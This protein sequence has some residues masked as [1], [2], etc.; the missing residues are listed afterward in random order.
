VVPQERAFLQAIRETGDDDLP[1]LVYA[2]WLEENSSSAA[3]R[4]RAEFI[5][6]QCRLAHLEPRDPTYPELHCRQLALLAEH[7]RDWLGEWADRLVRWEFDRGLLSGITVEPGPFALA[8]PLFAEH[9]VDRVAFVNGWGESLGPPAIRD[10]LSRKHIS[11]VRAIETAGCRPGEAMAAMFG[12]EIATSVWLQELAQAR[13]VVR[14]DE[15]SL[16]GGTRAGRDS[17]DPQALGAFCSA[18]HLKTLARLDLSDLYQTEWHTEWAG[19]LR[20]LASAAFA[21]NLRTLRLNRCMLADDAAAVLA[22]TPAFAQLEEL[23]LGGCD[24]IRAGGTRAILDSPFLT[25]LRDVVLPYGADLRV[26]ATCLRLA[27]RRSLGLEGSASGRGSRGRNGEMLPVGREVASEEWEP[28]FTSP[29]LGPE[30]LSVTAAVPV[31]TAAVQALVR[32]PWVKGLE[33]LHLFFDRLDTS[34][35]EEFLTD[36]GGLTRLRSFAL[37]PS[38]AFLDILIDWPGLAG[39][40]EFSFAHSYEDSV[41][42]LFRCPYLSAALDRLEVSATCRTRGEVQALAECK[43]LAGLRHLGFGY[44]S[45]NGPKMAALAASPWLRHL[46]SLHLGSESDHGRTDTGTVVDAFRILARPDTFPRLRD[47]VVGSETEDKSLELLRQRFGP[48]LRVWHD[49]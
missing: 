32:A 4:A 25:H 40:T 43:S 49:Y 34:P 47:V 27:K 21:S 38:G 13:Q 11:Q 20:I 12:G 39:L 22:N 45:L 14:L 36:Q 42:P 26:L 19:F 7:E 17:I 10:V 23:D 8:G 5:R 37:P 9:P 41:E 31:P 6:V 1:R 28:F 3:Q 46:E 29:H 35:F 48:R 44:N 2:D 24:F 30:R 15:L 16:F 18:E 33:V